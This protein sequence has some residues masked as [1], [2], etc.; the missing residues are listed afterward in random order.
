MRSGFPILSHSD[1]IYRTYFRRSGSYFSRLWRPAGK[2][3]IPVIAANTSFRLARRHNPLFF[4][5]KKSWPVLL[6]SAYVYQQVFSLLE[7]ILW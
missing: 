4:K 6:M 2:Q 3:V 7:A 5:E 1:M